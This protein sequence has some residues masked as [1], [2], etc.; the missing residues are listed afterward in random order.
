VAFGVVP[1]YA[2]QTWCGRIATMDVASKGILPDAGTDGGAQILRWPRPLPNAKRVLLVI[3]GLPYVDP[4]RPFPFTVPVAS[5]LRE[6][7]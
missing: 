3:S 6:T 2:M 7:H 4:D 5:R 1:N